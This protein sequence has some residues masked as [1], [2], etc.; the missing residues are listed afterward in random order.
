MSIADLSAIVVRLMS[1]PA[2][3]LSITFLFSVPFLIVRVRLQ[4]L[5]PHHLVPV[6]NPPTSCYNVCREKAAKELRCRDNR[7]AEQSI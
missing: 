5:M 3:N 2:A 7:Q 1:D 6:S 4:I